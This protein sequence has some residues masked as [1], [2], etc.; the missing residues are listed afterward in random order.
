MPNLSL[1]DYRPI[2]PLTNG[3]LST[4]YPALFRQCNFTYQ[5]RE[6]L[7]LLDLDFMDLDVYSSKS[8]KA[9]LLLHGL[10]GSSYSRYMIGAGKYFSNRGYDILA[11]NFRS[12]SGEMNRLPRLYH[13]GVSEDLHEVLVQIAHRYQ[14]IHIIGFSLGGNVMLKY[15]GEN[16]D[17]PRQLKAGAA[18]SPPIDLATC[19]EMVHKPSRKFY[20]NRFLKTLKSKIRAKA[21]QLPG[22][23][24]PK[25]LHN[26]KTLRE[27][28]NYYTA[29]LH[30]FKDGPDYY[31][32]VSAIHALNKLRK[33]ALMLHA[34]N[35]PI[36]GQEELPFEEAKKND[37]F[38]LAISPFGGHVGFQ[39]FMG[40]YYSDEL[41]HNFFE[42][43]SR[44]LDYAV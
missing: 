42:N 39:R 3:H 30:G 18:I 25:H 13:H 22:V 33:P 26:I 23:I 44:V 19:V 14:E 2:F 41:V 40:A 29:P 7:E 1:N 20:H 38:Y 43:R 31:E 6:R 10:E 35:D 8:H 11:L 27:F 34:M 36:I 16:W 4:I 24:D 17:F 32:K 37:N 12:C 28:D 9:V 15:F 21:D 5:K